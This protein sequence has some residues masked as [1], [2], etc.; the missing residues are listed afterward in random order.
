M[1]VAQNVRRTTYIK[2]F[3]PPALSN[4]HLCTLAFGKCRLL[5]AGCGMRHVLC[6]LKDKHG[7]AYTP[8]PSTALLQ[9]RLL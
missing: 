8:F 4:L 6:S 5:N 2:Y 7:I 1:V 3:L 9:R